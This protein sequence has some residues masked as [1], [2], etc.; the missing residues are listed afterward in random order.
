[1]EK[2]EVSSLK[3]IISDLQIDVDNLTFL[4][5]VTVLENDDLTQDV[6][7]GLREVNQFALCGFKIKE[8]ASGYSIREAFVTGAI[9]EGTRLGICLFRNMLEPMGDIIS[10]CYKSD[11]FLRCLGE[12][13]KGL[14]GE[15]IKVV[16]GCLKK[17]IPA[18]L[19]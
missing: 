8:E 19:T 17:Q 3:D 2:I 16:F 14:G 1:L 7:I 18:T 5:S 9:L 12:K 6:F 13:R 4:F 10:E 15:A 11:N